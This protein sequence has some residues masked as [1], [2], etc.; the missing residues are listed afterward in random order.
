MKRSVLLLVL[1]TIVSFLSSGQEPIYLTFTSTFQTLTVEPESITIS[2]LTNGGDTTL[3]WPDTILAM[4]PVSADHNQIPLQE[5]K[6]FQNFPNPV[7]IGTSSGTIIK[8]FIPQKGSLHLT[9]TNIN[10]RK[11]ASISKE[12]NKGY[13]NFSFLPGKNSIYIISAVFE[14]ETRSIKVISS[15]NSVNNSCSI[16]YLG[17]ETADNL[18]KALQSR[19]NFVYYTGDSLLMTARYLQ[20]TYNI[21]DTPIES[22]VYTFAFSEILGGDTEKTWKLLRDVSTGRFPLQVGPDDGSG[23]IWWAFGLHEQLAMRPCM[24]N[25]EWTLTSNGQML[26]RTQGDYWAEGGIF[27]PALENRCQPTTDM[28]GPLGE[29]L[30]AWGDGDHFYSQTEETVTVTGLGAYLAFLKTGTNM[31]VK[32]PQEEVIYSLIKLSEGTTDT[33]IVQCNYIAGDFTPAYWR[34]VLVHYDNP[35][36]EPP[37]PGPE[38]VAS[39]TFVQD[40]MTVYLTNTSVDADEYIWDFGDGTTSTEIHPSH[41][42]ASNG[43]YY[44]T[45]TAINANGTDEA[46]RF[47][48][49]SIENITNEHLVGGPWKVKLGEQTVFVGPEYGSPDWWAVPLIEME[50]G[51]PWSCLVNDEFIFSSNGNYEYQTNGDARNDGYMYGYP[52]GCITDDE[53]LNSG[54]GAAFRSAVHSY[55]FFSGDGI[56]PPYFILTNGSPTTSAFIGF[57]KGYYGGENSDPFYPPNGGLPTNRYEI[58]GYADDGVMEYLFLTVDINGA[59]PGNASWSYILERASTK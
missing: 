26:F 3:Y 58:L 39:F 25:D 54:N 49:F 10:G 12:V 37:I 11:I 32:F 47:V 55:N 36:D 56:N 50:P 27:H 2:N 18:H 51:G 44:I 57:Y 20:F 52:L 40:G 24:L 7:G 17:T 30:S 35:E 14:G 46:T 53:L 42:Y 48:F 23:T 34:Y 21:I 29:D 31:E 22:T 6:L 1:I 59:T 38:P 8:A 4:I 28:Y 19:S 43:F 13:S 5:F 33:L 41:T 16:K 45:L 9:V 15:Q